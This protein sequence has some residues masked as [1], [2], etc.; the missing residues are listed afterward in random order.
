MDAMNASKR[1]LNHEKGMKRIY[2][3]G[4]KISN[5]PNVKRV[6]ICGAPVVMEAMQRK[7]AAYGLTFSGLV[8]RAVNK[9]EG[10]K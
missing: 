5:P 7:A 1:K 6:Q 9:Y 8:I 4:L 2:K 10:D 3:H